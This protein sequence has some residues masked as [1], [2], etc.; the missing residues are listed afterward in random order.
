MTLINKMAVLAA[1]TLL[2]LTVSS[3]SS[4][5]GENVAITPLIA[6]D[7]VPEEP[8]VETKGL[9]A[10][11][12]YGSN[13]IYLGSSMSQNQP[14][15]YASLTYGFNLELYA[16]I[17]SMN[18][19]G[20][21]P[22]LS[23]HTGSLSYSH[24]FNSW[25][26]ISAG[27][28]GY[29]VHESLRDTLFPNF[30]YADA[31]LGLDWRILYTKVSVGGLLMDQSGLYLQIRNSRYFQTP[32]IFG[33]KANISFDPYVNLVLGT[34]T[35]EETST[36]TVITTLPRFGGGRGDG[37]TTGSGT[38]YTTRF[39]FIEMDFGLPVS[40]N[41]DFLSIEAEAG[42][43]VSVNDPSP[44]YSPEGFLFMVSAVFRLF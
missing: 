26:D 10:G 24:T 31:T 19:A 8:A 3:Q 17:S 37:T 2:T 7:T 36:G 35:Q 23:L 5:S 14:F 44:D 38:V 40:I 16:S 30:M 33:G 4:Y 34:M 39:G 25:F 29:Y 12:G 22:F 42:Y 13:M 18:L 21:S 20:F 11:L 32:E 1:A 27:I 6:S 43:V 41:F 15:G 9:Y 28:Y